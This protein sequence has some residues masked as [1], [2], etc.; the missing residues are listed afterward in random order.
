MNPLNESLIFCIEQGKTLEQ[1]YEYMQDKHNAGHRRVDT[2][3]RAKG[4]TIPHHV[5]G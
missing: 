2:L 4:L 1:V 5:E 3:L